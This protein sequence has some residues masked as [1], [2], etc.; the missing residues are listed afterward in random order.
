MIARQ[1]T[2]G[3]A[4]S[5]SPQGA[6]QPSDAIGRSIT[7]LDFGLAKVK[8]IGIA[9]SK[10]LTVPGTIMGTYAY[11]S[12]EQLSGVE[13]DERSDLFSIGVMVAEALTGS[14]PFP[15]DTVA[16]ILHSILHRPVHLEGDAEPIRTLEAVLQKCLAKDR[17]DRFATA[18]EMRHALIPALRQRPALSTS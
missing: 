14:R 10:S 3:S 16:E 17:Q 2:H 5:G 6:D 18:A 13:V 8:M 9:E 12:P 15:G 4:G 11:M 1:Y 7:I